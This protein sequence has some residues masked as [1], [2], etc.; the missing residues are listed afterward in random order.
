MNRLNKFLVRPIVVGLLVLSFFLPFVPTGNAQEYNAMTVAAAASEMG[1]VSSK[2]EVVYG[3]L[4]SA[5]KPLGIYVIN[6]LDVTTAGKITD[7]GEYSLIKNLTNLHDIKSK[8]GVVTTYSDT[9]KFYYQGNMKTIELPWEITIK[10]N[11]DGKEISA[12]ELVGQSG[13]LTIELA[14]K[15]NDKINRIFFENFMLQVSITLDT[16]KCRNI[17]AEEGM[18]ANA[19]R[20]KLVNFTVMPDA[21]GYMFINTDVTDFTM[22]GISI[23]AVP[24]SMNLELPDTSEIYKDL[25]TLS[26]AIESLSKGANEL[27]SGI[28]GLATGAK[29]L[30]DGS[31]K[32]KSGIEMFEKQI[33]SII[34]DL[35]KI[36]QSLD[37]NNNTLTELEKNELISELLSKINA[38]D[39]NYSEINPE[40]TD[41]R[42]VMAKL[43]S[44]FEELNSGITKLA[45]GTDQLAYGSGE[46]SS[47]LAELNKQT[48][49][50]PNQIDS[51]F[52][53]FLSTYD[54]SDYIP[55]SFVSDKNENVTAIQFTF[56]TDPIE[57]GK[58]PAINESVKKK[59]F[60]DRLK[61]LF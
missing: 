27:N 44:G 13:N 59:T 57:K 52:D 40:L 14:T 1:I 61:N 10:Y 16:N 60:W 41:Y 25:N 18:L 32:Y 21:D 45:D 4:D 12:Q 26:G 46:L 17:I 55:I 29:A 3:K 24:F 2:E 5:G 58:S 22:K 20:D 43:T 7:Y 39:S 34:S 36:K 53:E 31:L 47:G 30:K 51:T 54:T 9:N 56:I 33:S 38:L 37:P 15:A 11:L 19:G 50:M 28:N 49:N 42:D 48:K 23:S 6:I 35:L 8:N